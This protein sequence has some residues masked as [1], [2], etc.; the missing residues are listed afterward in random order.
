MP[1][2]PWV[3]HRT[4]DGLHVCKVSISDCILVKDLIEKIRKPRKLGVQKSFPI[5]P[6]EPFGATISVDKCPSSHMSGNSR[7]TPIHADVSVPLPIVMERAT[8]SSLTSFWNS[9]WE[10]SAEDNFLHFSV[11]PEFFP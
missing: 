8:N 3:I 5:T 4:E 10:L 6:H 7:D 9:L 2:A 1:Q 11:I